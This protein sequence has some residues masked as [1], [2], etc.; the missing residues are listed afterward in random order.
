MVPLAVASTVT[1]AAGAICAARIRAKNVNKT[2][3]CR[4]SELDRE[5]ERPREPKAS[6]GRLSLLLFLRMGSRGRSPSLWN[7]PNGLA[8]TAADFCKSRNALSFC[9]VG[10]R[11]KREFLGSAL[12]NR[13]ARTL[14]LPVFVK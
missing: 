4:E 13:L 8:R 1:G 9:R 12:E 10:S 3:K 11:Q 5:G 14:A 2:T 7:P 6:Y